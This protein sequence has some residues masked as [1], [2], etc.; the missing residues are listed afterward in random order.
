MRRV[1]PSDEN[2]NPFVNMMT[3]FPN[4]IHGQCRNILSLHLSNVSSRTSLAEETP[5]CMSFVASPGSSSSGSRT[6]RACHGS[7]RAI[8]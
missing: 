1:I 3:S 6:R 5:R 7:C 8:P 2:R 4:V